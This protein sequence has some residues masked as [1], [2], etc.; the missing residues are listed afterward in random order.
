MP[1]DVQPEDLD[2]VWVLQGELQLD[3]FG[4]PLV[5]LFIRRVALADMFEHKTIRGSHRRR[6]LHEEEITWISLAEWADHLIAADPVSDA[7]GQFSLPPVVE[8]LERLN[9]KRE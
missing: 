3:L 8:R 9:T 2:E 4:E 5:E 1:V 6:I 7:A